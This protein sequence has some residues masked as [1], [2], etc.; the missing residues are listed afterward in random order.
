TA[1]RGIAFGSRRVSPGDLFVAVPGFERDGLEFVPQALAGGAVAIVAERD[2]D[3][4]AA[5]VRVRS[6]RQALA[7]LSAAFYGHPSRH[8]PVVGVTGTDGK[9]STTH[10]LSAILRAHGLRTGWLTTVNTRIGDDIRA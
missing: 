6:A 7:D 1:V 4:S 8:I 10:L 5:L 2:T 3:A 9:T